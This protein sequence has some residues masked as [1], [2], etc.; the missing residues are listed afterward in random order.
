MPLAASPEAQS[1]TP[2]PRSRWPLL[3]L[4]VGIAA[5]FWRMHQAPPAAPFVPPA[6]G[7]LAATA[8]VTSTPPPT[9]T[10][11]DASQPADQ[12]RYQTGFLPNPGP[13]EGHAASMV[14]LP[15]GRMRAFW[16]DGN[17]GSRDAVIGTSVFDP[18]A[19]SWSPPERVTGPQDHGKQLWRSVRKVGNA[20]AHRDDDG[21]IW[22]YYV[23]V[24]VGGWAG[25]SINS[26]FSLDDGKTWSAPKRLITSP[27]MN[28]STLVR[29]APVV[30]ADGTWGLPVYH[31]LLDMFAMIARIGRDGQLVDLQRIN[32]RF[33]ALQATVLVQDARRALVFLRNG[34]GVLPRKVYATETVDAGQ[35]WL[36]TH[37]TQ[38]PNPGA[39]LAGLVLEDGTMLLAM[40]RAE[41]RRRNMSLMLSSDGGANWQEVH[42]FENQALES[43]ARVERSRYITLTRADALKAGVSEAEADKAAGYAADIRCNGP[44]SCDFEYSYPFLARA[45]NG[46]VFLMYTWNRSY[47]RWA[48]FDRAWIQA[49]LTRRARVQ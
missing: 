20:V 4:A 2:G 46:D 3:V 14:A 29:H 28:L 16:I 18:S 31:E 8:A 1:G 17:E 30:Y 36:P 24:S 42:T 37:E 26:R 11:A 6:A 34:T 35:R 38:L 7:A 45:S 21:R 15:D 47:I 41:V 13:R 43:S 25:S 22:L 48:R 5:A 27:F 32:D 40:N 10:P 23:T 44:A 33:I 39:P 19:G 9:F 49:E 12:G